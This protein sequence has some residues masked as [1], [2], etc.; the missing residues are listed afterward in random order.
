VVAV[1]EVGEGCWR[2]TTWVETAAVVSPQAN[3]IV[4][5]S[6]AISDSPT[7][8]R[9]RELIAARFLTNT[10]ATLLIRLIQPHLSPYSISPI[11]K[12]HDY[13]K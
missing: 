6:P 13:A 8:A 7:H 10:A 5:D 2:G 11:D 9:Q 3:S 12:P 1:S 4:A